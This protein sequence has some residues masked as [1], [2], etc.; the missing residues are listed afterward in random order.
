MHCLLQDYRL[1][2]VYEAY[3]IIVIRGFML[4]T[5]IYTNLIGISGEYKLCKSNCDSILHQLFL[6]FLKLIIISLTSLIKQA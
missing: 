6:K 2:V 5:L 1:T 4:Y 3:Y